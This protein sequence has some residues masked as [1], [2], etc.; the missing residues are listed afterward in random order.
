MKL[1]IITTLF[2]SSTYLETFFESASFAANDFAGEDYEIIFV[3]DGSPDNS[4]IV[5][6]ELAKR[7]SRITIIDLSRNFGHHK[8]MMT[9][10]AHAS[11]DHIFLIDSDLEED[12]GWLSKFKKIMIDEDADVVFGIQS[13]RKG[14]FFEKITGFIYYKILSTFTIISQPPNITTARLMTKR[15]VDALILHQERE[16]NIGGLWSITGFK[17]V[18]TEVRKLSTSQSTYTFRMKL[19][20]LVNAI[21]SF[22]S[23]PLLYIFYIGVGVTIT[24]IIFISYLLFVYFFNTP[25]DGYTSIVASIWLLSGIIISMQGILGIYISKIFSEVKQRPFT[26]IKETINFKVSKK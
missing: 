21:T 1:S 11:G 4:L 24:A 23:K 9:G 10:L 3:N 2:N 17:Q 12:V 19:S 18:S 15:Y 16:L 8:A 22:S 7:D 26:I 13:N 20:E 14:D 6:T 5:A 25:P